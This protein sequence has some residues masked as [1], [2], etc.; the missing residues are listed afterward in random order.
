MMGENFFRILGFQQTPRWYEEVVMKN[1]VPIMIGLYLILPTILN[2]YVVSGAFE[3][4]LD[5]D[6]MI[7]SKLATG[8]M[9]NADDLLGPLTKAGL[10]AIER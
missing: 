5:G 3:I 2:G 7:F 10:T 8:R 6:Q 4:M 1:A 9:P